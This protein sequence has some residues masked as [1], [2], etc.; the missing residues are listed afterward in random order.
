MGG[1][2]MGTLPSS[3]GTSSMVPPTSYTQS[4][5]SNSTFVNPLSSNNPSALQQTAFNNPTFSNPVTSTLNQYSLPYSN[6]INPVT[7][8]FSN[9]NVTFSNPLSSQFNSLPLT[10]GPM[11]IKLKPIDDVDLGECPYIY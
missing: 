3:L 2:V 5:M 6:P 7:T 10:G 4:S 11:S 1:G 8:T 9:N